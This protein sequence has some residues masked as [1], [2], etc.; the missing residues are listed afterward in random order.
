M[1]THTY[2]EM[3]AL[4]DT[5]F[6]FVG[7]R[8]FIQKALENLPKKQNRILDV[9]IGTGGT[10]S[11]LLRYGTVVGLEEQSQAITLARKRGLRV[12]R[13]TANSLPFPNES[14]DVVTFFDV[15]YHK[16]I[17]EKRALSEA[18]RVL[19]PNG[20]LCITDCALPWFW[21][22]HDVV[23][24]A[25]YRYTKTKLSSFVLHA[26]FSI[27]RCEYIFTSVFL[28]F[29]CSRFF[30]PSPH[31]LARLPLFFNDLLVLLLRSETFLPWW[32]PRPFGSSILI[33]AHKQ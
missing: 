28:F 10:T 9:G 14:F 1:Q 22:K 11:F 31:K 4:E 17:D 8:L 19:K 15:L 27:D 32:F 18:F 23:M 13:G 33:L 3:Y 16:G 21:S 6:W 12:V 30:Q 26:G 25:K 5:H 20:V 2:K 7:K 24:E 29:I